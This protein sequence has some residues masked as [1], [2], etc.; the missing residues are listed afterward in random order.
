MD[1]N[2]QMRAEIDAE[3]AE[4]TD[5]PWWERSSWG[6]KSDG[7]WRLKEI[8]MFKHDYETTRNPLFVWAA[9]KEAALLPKEP[10]LGQAA[11]RQWIEDYLEESAERLMTS[12]TNPPA[13]DVKDFAERNAPA[14]SPTVTNA[15]T[16]LSSN[17]RT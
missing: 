13:T 17:E 15:P 7:Y 5:I 12:I 11:A 6:R 1:Y 4:N 16:R 14:A 10:A 2:D 3:R 8:E 9:R